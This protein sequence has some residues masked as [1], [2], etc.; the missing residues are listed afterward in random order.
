M[1]TWMLKILGIVL[2]GSILLGSLVGCFSKNERATRFGN[3]MAPNGKVKVLSTIAQIGDLVEEIG[4]ERVDGLVLIEGDLDPHSYELVKGDD[5]K[6]S[7]ADA[8]FYNGLGL[9]HGAS[10]SNSLRMHPKGLSIGDFIKDHLNQKIIMNNRSVDPHIWMDISLWKEAVD[11]I[12]EQLISIDPEGEKFYRSQADKL[13]IKM[14]EAHLDLFNTL[15]KVPAEKRYL[16]TSH[17]A[18]HYF[19]KAYL[20]DK[21]DGAAWMERVAAPEGLAPDG[22]LNPSDIFA[23]IDYLRAKKI[24][25]IFPESNVSRDSIKKIMAAGREM[26]LEIHICSEVLYGDAMGKQGKLHYL[27]MMRHNGDVISRYLMEE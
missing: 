16:V 25:V 2:L 15:Q 21:K 1:K 24:S 12:V 22:Q 6:I 8:I 18:F 27:E 7:R 3:W 19:T 17:D 4:G 20:T 23:I 14:D 10:L 9:E 11:P 26:G 13:K 5:E